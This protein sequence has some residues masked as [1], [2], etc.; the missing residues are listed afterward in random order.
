[1]EY[2]T[3]H[4]PGGKTYKLPMVDRRK[5]KQGE[6]KK[7][8]RDLPGI[9]LYIDDNNA[10]NY[11]GVGVKVVSR[12]CGLHEPLPQKYWEQKIA[13]LLFNPCHRQ[14]WYP[15]GECVRVRRA[16]PRTVVSPIISVLES[17]LIEH[18]NPPL[19]FARVSRIRAAQWQKEYRSQHLDFTA[20]LY[21]EPAQATSDKANKSKRYY[22]SFEVPRKVE[23][24]QPSLFDL[25]QA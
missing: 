19:N 7:V 11:V 1:L 4:I 20:E 15:T 14:K 22:F 9:Y 23:Y 6:I 16:F 10:V 3:L 17:Y 13:F 25:L 8:I 21:A 18:L 12:A 2:Y 24:F 5:L